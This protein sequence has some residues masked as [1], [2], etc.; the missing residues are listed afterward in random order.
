METEKYTFEDWFNGTIE[1]HSVSDNPDMQLIK[2]TISSDT[3]R[4]IKNFQRDCFDKAVEM[5]VHLHKSFIELDLQ[6]AIDLNHY[7]ELRKKR[8]LN[9]I[10]SDIEYHLISGRF[11]SFNHFQCKE[12]NTYYSEY[13][14]KNMPIAFNLGKGIEWVETAAKLKLIKYLN[15]L[16]ENNSNIP[17]YHLKNFLIEK[18]SFETVNKRIEDYK[19]S[20]TTYVDADNKIFYSAALKHLKDLNYL[21]PGIRQKRHFPL[22][23]LHTW[24]VDIS[25]QRKNFKNTTT[26]YDF[27]VL[28]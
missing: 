22:I 12:I 17:E 26:K 18:F 23:A 16:N 27:D 13:F 15:T 5:R 21:I 28:K 14:L 25:G 24:N 1:E 20:I 11:Y 6:T 2:G 3:Y 8:F 7:I 4:D 10:N 9:Q 19:N